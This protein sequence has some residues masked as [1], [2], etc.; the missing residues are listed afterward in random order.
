MATVTGLTSLAVLG[1]P[2]ARRMPLELLPDVELP[3][4]EV[5]TA[6]PEASPEQ[7]EALVSSPIEAAAQEIGRVRSVSSTS[8]AQ[9]SVVTVEFEPGTGMEFAR[10]DLSE[11]LSALARGLPPGALPPEV[12]PWVPH[13]LATGTRA[14]LVYTVAG[15]RVLGALRGYAEKELARV[16]AAAPGVGAVEVVGGAGLEIQVRL[17]PDRMTALGIAPDDV[18]RALASGLNLAETGGSLRVGERVVTIAIDDRA[19]GIADVE[20][21]VVEPRGSGP[22]VRLDEVSRVLLAY[23]E[24]REL[25]RLDGVPAVALHL[26][27]VPGTNAIEVADRVRERIERLRSTLPIGIR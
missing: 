14:L 17:Q 25:H 16:L 4:L 21:L 12:E 3:R 10:L 6:W 11:R 19:G 24:P 18:R 13:D 5:S 22:A 7:V 26:H 15:P 8:Y 9:R 1:I 20:A 27:R 2:A 23:A